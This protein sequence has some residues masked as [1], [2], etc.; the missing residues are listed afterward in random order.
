MRAR[1]RSSIPVDGGEEGRFS[2]LRFVIKT[3]DGPPTWIR[4]AVCIKRL[5]YVSAALFRPAPRHKHATTFPILYRSRRPR[6]L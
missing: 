4:H 6:H 3:Y 1:A 2:F 5:N